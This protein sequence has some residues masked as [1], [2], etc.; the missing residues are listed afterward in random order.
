MSDPNKSNRRQFL[1]GRAAADALADRL[2][3]DDQAVFRDPIAAP[4]LVDFTRGAMACEFT[5]SLNAGQYPGVAAVALLALDVVDQLEDQMTVYRDTSEIAAIN[6]RAADE[7]VEVEPRL[8]DLLM[9]CQELWRQT[10]GAFDI[11]SGPLSKVWGFYRRQGGMPEADDVQR[12]L[13]L[14][15]GDKLQLDE[16]RCVVAF[17][18]DGM[19]LNLGSIGKGYALDRCAEMLEDSGVSDFLLVGSLSSVTAHGSHAVADS[20]VRPGPPD[21]AAQTGWTVGVKDP[22]R[23]GRRLAEICLR[24]RALATSGSGAQ[25][26]RY[27]GRRYGHILD[28]RSGQP[29][30]GVFSATAVA[31]SAADADALATAFYTMGPEKT[32]AYCESHPDVTAL[33]VCSG[34][35]GGPVEVKIAGAFGD[36]LT[37]NT[38]ASDSNPAQ[39]Q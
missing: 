15:G 31:P 35:N 18:T 5:L 20:A 4:Y 22:L 9:R 29:V 24:D 38:N 13:A 7:P 30:E 19:E 25:F 10:D 34:E 36:D 32:A 37:M 3:G 23:P 2:A 21:G 16:E 8:F 17:A 28:P 27:K 26:F 39:E 33:L 6:R 12:A 14:V 11:T 1:S